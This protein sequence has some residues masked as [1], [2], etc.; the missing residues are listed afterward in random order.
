MAVKLKVV[1]LIIYHY[2]SVP[3]TS[4]ACTES[5]ELLIN[6]HIIIV[7]IKIKANTPTK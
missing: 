4:G 5:S 6:L 2:E 1:N 3:K 7:M